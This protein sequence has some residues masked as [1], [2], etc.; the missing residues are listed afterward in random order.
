MVGHDI[1]ESPEFRHADDLDRRAMPLLLISNRARAPCATHDCLT[2]PFA[3]YQVVDH[4]C[5]K[6]AERVR[7]TVGFT[8]A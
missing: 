8:I 7:P 3:A 2:A 6:L 4:I 1:H 5:A